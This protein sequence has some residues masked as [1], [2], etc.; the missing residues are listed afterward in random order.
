[1]MD[2]S[3]IYHN[4]AVFQ[5][6]GRWD[7]DWV[8]TQ[9]IVAGFTNYDQK[10]RT[11]FT[12]RILMTTSASEKLS[13]DNEMKKDGIEDSGFPFNIHALPSQPN[14]N[15]GTETIDL[16]DR[17]K[18]PVCG[19]NGNINSSSFTDQFIKHQGVVGPLAVIGSGSDRQYICSKMDF[20]DI[21]PT[22]PWNDISG[23]EHAKHD[24]KG[25]RQFSV[26]SPEIFEPFG[27]FHRYGV[28]FYGLPGCGKILVATTVANECQNIFISVKD[29]E[30]LNRWI[31]ASKAY[32]YDYYIKTY[33]A[34]TC[35]LP[36]DELNSNTWRYDGS[37]GDS[38]SAS[39]YVMERLLLAGN[40]HL[41][42]GVGVPTFSTDSVHNLAAGNL[43]NNS[44]SFVVDYKL[45]EGLVDR[46]NKFVVY[47]VER[48]CI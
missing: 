32:V 25:F 21:V 35:F 9:I 6:F 4:E 12:K 17:F 22:I 8:L 18:D 28:L 39:N 38:G 24:L 26:G 43:M 11:S 42:E 16:P 7:G 15:D 14:S 48:I 31:V 46:F 45:G 2:I 5:T 37:P 36:F 27:L 13:I 44:L 10:N 40:V 33:Q 3:E 41:G 20:I 30:P 1:M 47:V 34:A 23:W 29:L 19:H